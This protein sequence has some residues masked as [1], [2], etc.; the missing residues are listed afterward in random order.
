MV[1]LNLWCTRISTAGWK[2]TAR[3]TANVSGS[4]ISLTAASAATTMIVAAT[5]RRSSKP[6][7]QFWESP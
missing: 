5:T 3:T 1:G 6:R 7:R 4:T 2:I